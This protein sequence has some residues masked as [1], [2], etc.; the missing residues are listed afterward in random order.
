MA[1][2][3]RARLA[4]ILEA[5]RK[6][7]S[8]S[9]GRT[10]QDLDSDEMYALAMVRLLEIIGEAATSISPAFKAANPQIPW[11]QISGTRN[12]LIHG[13]FNVDHDIVWQIIS[14]DLPLL[15]AEITKLHPPQMP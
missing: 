15:I 3:D 14:G 7:V 1:L 9:T 2:D 12:R 10:R 6:T 8:F 4:H 11:R 5:A 13:Y